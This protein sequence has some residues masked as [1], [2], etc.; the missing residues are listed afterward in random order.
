M[1]IHKLMLVLFGAICAVTAAAGKIVGSGQARA[2]ELEK[3]FAT[4]PV[5]AKPWV[6]CFWLEG[7]VTRQG[8]TADL[9]AMQR[10][11]IG[12]LLFMDGDMGNPKGPH[13]FMSESWRAMFKQMVSEADRLGLEINL[14]N[15][16]GW[17]GS[18]GP[19]VKPEQASQKV[20]ASETILQ[21]PVHLD[22]M[23]AQPPMTKKFYRD[24]V[25]LACPAPTADAA[26]KFRRIENYNSTKSFAGGQDFEGVVPWPRVICTDPQW[27]TVPESQCIASGKVLDLSGHMAPD[28]R[29]QWDVP[30]GRWLIIRI[31]HTLAGGT[32]RSSQAEATGLE[33]DKLSKSAV[34]AHFSAMVGKLLVDIGPLARKTVVSAHIDSWEAGSGNWT[35]G[36]RD[37]F[38]R[39]RGY[40][41]TPYLPT[42]NGLVVDSLEVSERFLWDY[43]ETVC[44]MLLENYAGEMQ[45]LSH[46][47]GLRLSI[48]AYDG[49]CDDLRYAGRADEPMCE[50]WQRGCY[51]G[52]PLCD[53][54]EEMAS[55][56]HVYGDRILG[57]EAFTGWRGDFLDHPATLKPLGDWAFCAG[58]NRFCFS[59]W[60]MQPW[61][62]RVPGLSFLSIG[63]VFH[64]SL[65]WWE[66]SKPWHEYV[67]RC[68]H[69]LRQGQ[70]V[71][72]VCFVA[73]EGGPYRFV[74]PIPAADRDVL[75]VRPEYNFDGC[76]AELV[77]HGM[78]VQDGRIVLPTGMSYRLLVLPS[79][80][81]DGQPIRHIEGNY[82]YT[83]SP[84][85][86]VETMTPQ[87]LRRVKE[88]VHAGAT[89]LG[90]RPLKSPSLANFPA[91]DQEL[92][93][94]ADDLWGKNNVG[95][96]GSGEHRLGK[97]RVIWGTTPE[98][99]LAGMAVPPDFDC[100][101]AVKGKLL[102][103]HRRMND[104][105]ELYFVA[106]KVDGVAQGVCSFRAAT[107]R[108]E[109]WWPETG[110]IELIAEYEH[111]QGVTRV[112]LR[113]DP[114][115]SV[116]VVFHPS[117]E[118]FDPVI[119]MTRDSQNVLSQAP[120][121]STLVVKKAVYGVPDDPVRTR[122]VTAKVQDIVAGGER[123]FAGWRLG[124]GDDPG[125]QMLKSLE[126]NYTLD[127]KPRTTAV[128]DG[129]T[130]CL[131]DVDVADSV[132]TA[133]AQRAT[134]GD[135]LLEAWRNGSYELK[136]ASGR[137]L[138][139]NVD[140][141]SAA[142]PIEGPWTVL[143]PANSGVL[144]S[145][146]LDKLISWS[147]YTDLGVKYFSGTA[148]YQKTF[149]VSPEA[150]T[151]GHAV[152][153]DLGKVA[154]MAQIR[155]NG[156]DLGILWKSPFRVEATQ[157]LHPG[158][159]L[160]EVKV[161]NLW[162]NRMIGDAQL[163]EDSERN[164]TG[165]LKSWPKWLLE[166][167]P[168]PA[169]RHT[170][171]TYSIWKKD[172]PLQESGLLGPVTLRTVAR[173]NVQ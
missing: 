119:S 44:E 48:E 74:A 98:R 134:N 6:Y 122:D 60:I 111:T 66:Q 115:E 130:V 163:P 72:D 165:Q 50:F 117:R 89:V 96:N 112:P 87:L 155:L 121:P 31:G 158:E 76:P 9:E 129:Q 24:I 41:L 53:I 78:K 162:V 55:A 33:C 71:A 73:P 144:E 90:T 168:S 40:D 5:A 77:L 142:Q 37:E 172:S 159:N 2:N 151:A 12:G 21:G 105:L 156:R 171:A 110:R 157:A 120:F 17:A 70:F 84:L 28:G 20:V 137:T 67:A 58:V 91:C 167:R 23:L 56:A 160:L 52:L 83:R 15:D 143:F 125:M 138:N 164:P 22:A 152:Y 61:P 97:G 82:V 153:L 8:I 62:N 1:K 126:I 80:N 95:S 127:G 101:S 59:E 68:Q 128:L 65:T 114:H 69:M 32:T 149:R 3:N 145:V 30:P 173:I 116:F 132:P 169:G 85:P 26:G 13:R 16:P 140:G 14:N 51:S 49:T 35:A 147:Q 135:L 104:G 113:L 63:T 81:A 92:T 141:I 106:N 136:T 25:V 42:L 79:Y 148:T 11:G 133:R 93:E 109:L 7:N 18:G 118:V 139:C 45:K 123:R 64:R 103:T 166:G 102:Y 29:L 10:A 43:R 170:F 54:V 108:P 34:D 131:E 39:R 107:G 36:F 161:T 150:L 47:K 94:L 19:W 100:D 38:R 124:E 4:P 146:T 99:I 27:P 75:H 88:L 57:A 46:Q 86:K 154:V